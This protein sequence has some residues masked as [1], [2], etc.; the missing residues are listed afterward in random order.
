MDSLIWLCVCVGGGGGE[1]EGGG[2][3]GKGV[4]NTSPTST[5]AWSKAHRSSVSS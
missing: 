4:I 2:K 1:G 3:G 5:V